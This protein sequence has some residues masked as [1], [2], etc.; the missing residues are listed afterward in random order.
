MVPT[1]SMRTQEPRFYTEYTVDECVFY[2]GTCILLVY[3]DDTIVLGPHKSEVKRVVEMLQQ[4]FNMATP[5]MK[6]F[7][8]GVL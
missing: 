6:V 8:I 7:T 2:H 4:T 5:L 3:V 1:S